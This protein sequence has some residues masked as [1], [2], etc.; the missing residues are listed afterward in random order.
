M[1]RLMLLAGLLVLGLVADA[2][3]DIM[4]PSGLAPGDQFREVFVTITTTPATSSNI[5]FYDSIVQAN[6][7]SGGLATYNGSPVTWETLGSTASVSAVSRLPMDN[8]PIYLPNGTEVATGGAALWATTQ[9]TNPLLSAI[10]EY[11]NGTST[12]A[13][14]SAN[15]WTGTNSNGSAGTSEF[16]TLGD[17]ST[18]TTLGASSAT[19]STWVEQFGFNQSASLSLYGFSEVL[20]VPTPSTATPE[21]ASITL[22]L[23]GVGGLVGFCLARRGRRASSAALAAPPQSH[24]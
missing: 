12:P 4:T 23:T 1:N 15:V 19:F 3:A 22:V 20:T 21:P 2:R 24:S 13:G 18:I 7:V 14:G 6:A 5:S 17:S 10:D 9:T 16:G 8:I 11:S